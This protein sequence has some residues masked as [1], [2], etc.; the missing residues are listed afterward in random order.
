MRKTS[1]VAAI[2]RWSGYDFKGAAPRYKAYLEEFP[3]SERSHISR[4]RHAQSLLR[5]AQPG[6]AVKAVDAYQNYPV[7]FQRDLVKAEALAAMGEREAAMSLLRSWLLSPEAETADPRTL[8]E[9]RRLMAR[10]E[11]MGALAPDFETY[12]YDG[13]PI[14]MDQ[15]K[16]KVLLIDFWRSTCNPCMNELPLIADMYDLHKKDGFEVFAVN[17]DTNMDSMTT[18]MEIIGA[19]WP[20]YHDGLAFQGDLAKAFSVHRTPTTILVDR[21]G[22]IRAFDVRHDGIEAMLP[23]LLRESASN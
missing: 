5:S 1:P 8:D 7:A 16:G 4:T 17:M 10:I 3:R 15:F 18:A 23:G 14:S 13:F 21:N 12:T 2:A 20:V 19:D 22:M 9:G 6:L 11:S